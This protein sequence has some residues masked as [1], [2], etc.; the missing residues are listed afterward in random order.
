MIKEHNPNPNAVEG[1]I[2]VRRGNSGACRFLPAG[3]DETMQ[4]WRSQHGNTD[5]FQTPCLYRSPGAASERIYP[6]YFRITADQWESVRDSA[7]RIAY[8]LEET[9]SIP[10]DCIEFIYS[11]NSVSGTGST[12]GSTGSPYN[13]AADPAG[14]AGNEDDRDGRQHGAAGLSGLGGIENRDIVHSRNGTLV[15][16]CGHD[17]KNSPSIYGS[18][19]GSAPKPRRNQI[20]GSNPPP[21]EVV[22]IIPTLVLST[23]R[24]P[25]TLRINFELSRAICKVGIR[26]VDTDIYLADWVMRIPNSFNTVAGGYVIPL[27]FDELLNLSF[28]RLMSL[29]GSGRSEDSMILPHPVPGAAKWFWDLYLQTQRDAKQQQRLLQMVLDRGWETPPCIDRL[30]RIK[31]HADGFLLES[32]RILVWWF[33]WVGASPAQIMKELSGISQGLT[34]PSDQQKIHSILS[35]SIENPRFAG[36]HHPL[37]QRHCPAEKCYMADLIR[38][39]EQPHLFQPKYDSKEMEYGNHSC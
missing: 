34:N 27:T 9:A 14:P 24:G 17:G 23:V 35:L 28:S 4:S 18:T 11:G 32:I 38:E 33:A 20:T 29:A 21:I 37:L 6:L 36:C 2:C 10:P 22:V 16:A 15:N 39:Y 26:Y 19:D 3:D 1:Y 7:I 30:K 31:T 13:L 25:V 12:T 5:L 8:F